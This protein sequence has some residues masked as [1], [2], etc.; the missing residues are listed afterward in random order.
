[1]P[2]YVICIA[3]ALVSMAMAGLAQAESIQTLETTISPTKLDTKK[4]KSVRIGFDIKTGPNSGAA[5]NQDQPPNA[6][7]TVVDFPKNLKIDTEGTP[8]CAVAPDQLENTSTEQAIELCGVK[9]IISVPSASSAHVTADSNPSLP[10]SATIPI[11]VVLTAFNGAT[12]DT[13]IF[14]NRAES[15]NNTTVLDEKLAKSKD[16]KYGTSLITNIPPVLA[17]GVDR[18]MVTIKRGTVASARCKSK[19]NPFQITSTFPDLTPSNVSSTTTTKC[20]Q[21]KKS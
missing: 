2:K 5:V 7:R 4:F 13:L 10:G 17:G 8:H 18:F 20:T 16:S 14:H 1:M 15:V 3:V 19:K 12:K 6:S 9:S 11:E 21:K